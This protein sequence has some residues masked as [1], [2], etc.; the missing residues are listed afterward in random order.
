MFL[1][2]ILNYQIYYQGDHC[3]LINFYS[4]LYCNCDQYFEFIYFKIYCYDL[5]KWRYQDNKGM[6]KYEANGVTDVGGCKVAW[7][8]VTFTQSNTLRMIV[9]SGW[10][11]TA[12]L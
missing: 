12:L 3:F 8:A 1:V 9:G 7:M 11:M 4:D 6:S 2:V 10:F 5:V